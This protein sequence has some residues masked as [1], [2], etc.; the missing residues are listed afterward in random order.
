MSKLTWK[1]PEMK[2][3]CHCWIRFLWSRCWWASHTF[4]CTR[5]SP[6]PAWRSLALGARLAAGVVSSL[7]PGRAAAELAWTGRTERSLCSLG[8]SSSVSIWS[9]LLCWPPVAAGWAPALT[10][11]PAARLRN[12]PPSACVGDLS[13]KCRWTGRPVPGG[14]CCCGGDGGGGGVALRS[15]RL[16]QQLLPTPPPRRTPSLPRPWCFLLRLHQQTAGPWHSHRK[17]GADDCCWSAPRPRLRGWSPAPLDS[18][19]VD[20]RTSSRNPQCVSSAHSPSPDWAPRS[21]GKGAPSCKVCSS[22]WKTRI[23]RR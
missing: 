10:W 4:L 1:T 6:G 8:S 12:A 13:Q 17:T 16:P 18:A 20:N 7:P 14:G 22:G 3:C 15:E 23:P 19:A 9:P 11:S 2:G 5:P 21:L